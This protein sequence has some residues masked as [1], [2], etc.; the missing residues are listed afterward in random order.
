MTEMEGVER[1]I[2]YPEVFK[3]KLGIGEDAFASL[4]Q[5]KNLEQVLEVFNIAIMGGAGAAA[6]SSSAVATTFFAP[7]GLLAALGVGATAAT[8]IGWVI[9]AGVASAGGFFGIRRYLRSGR[10]DRVNV[11]PKWINTPLDALAVALF[12]FFAPLGIKVAALDGEMKPVERLLITEY[13]VREWGY[14]ERFVQLAL[15]ELEGNVDTFPIVELVDNLIEFKKQSPDCDFDALSK[16]LTSFLK[17][18]TRADGK[19]HELE[20][21][22]IQWL[23]IT[24]VRGKPG[25]WDELH[26][27]V[28]FNRKSSKKT[29]GD[30]AS[31][32]GSVSVE[33]APNGDG[34]KGSEDEDGPTHETHA[35]DATWTG[36][37]VRSPLR[38]VRDQ[39]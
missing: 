32:P 25:F 38:W 23:E 29:Q 8:P 20:V 13:F 28:G 33:N 16:E 7:A 9:A 30:V 19:L 27:A 11:G 24:L 10:E 3:I 39:L 35:P 31:V 37:N 1:V 36:R 6:A 26:S 21:M 14:S 17:E 15:P 5:K 12:D 18:V 22:F 34:Y 2:T 4:R